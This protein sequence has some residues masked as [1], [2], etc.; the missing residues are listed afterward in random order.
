MLVAAILCVPLATPAWASGFV[1]L[2]AFSPTTSEWTAARLFDSASECESARLEGESLVN[3]ERA[4]N[5]L[6]PLSP[7]KSLKC[8]AE[9][10]EDVAS[11]R[12]DET[13]QPLRGQPVSERLDQQ[14]SFGPVETV[15]QFYRLIEKRAYTEAWALFSSSYRSQPSAD[16]GGWVRGFADTRS[17]EVSAT[18]AGGSADTTTVAVELVSVDSTTDGDVSK[19][20]AGTWEL[21]REGA[22]WRLAH[23]NIHLVEASSPAAKGTEPATHL[24]PMA[25][26]SQHGASATEVRLVKTGGVY[27]VP[28]QIN[29]AITLDFIVDSGAAEVN[30]PADVVMT[31]IRANTIALSDFLP[32]A[33]YV[34]ADGTRLQSPRF[35]IRMVR[36]G[37]H[38]LQNV[39]ASIGE[40]TSQL[41]LGQSVLE[42]LGQ[43]SLDS[44]RGVMVL[45]EVGAPTESATIAARQP[46]WG[47]GQENG[48]R[49]LPDSLPFPVGTSREKVRH[50]LGQPSF[51]KQPGYWANTTIDR[52]DDVMPQWLTLSY[53]YDTSTLRV[54]QT[55]AS[56]A[57]WAG[58]D[59]LSE[60]IARM[61]GRSVGN[62][63][64]GHSS[65]VGEQGDRRAAFRVGSLE[66]TIERQD[67]SRIFVAVWEPGTHRAVTT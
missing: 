57:N 41:L 49:Q 22:R 52:F 11:T 13:S 45:G 32:G 56:F 67:E 30:I 33:T 6:E 9:G 10:D 65:P 15:R 48:A 29:G 54:R 42:R 1:R 16:F 7:G 5:D 50:R 35:T 37:D 19:R 26:R 38:V 53:L 44:R 66:G 47:L 8:L 63:C 34:L 62:M 2:W 4:R 40:V 20:F 28:V 55:E 36:L 3:A 24:A 18:S 31:L 64:G 39:S 21:V 14:K 61:A 17:I 51:E 12:G 59:Y 58:V 27:T 23:P 25:D 46:Q 43:W 60:A